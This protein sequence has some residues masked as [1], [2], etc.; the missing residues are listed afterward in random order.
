M[1]T[2]LTSPNWNFSEVNVNNSLELTEAGD[3]DSVVETFIVTIDGSFRGTD[4]GNVAIAMPFIYMTSPGNYASWD[5]LLADIAEFVRDL[6]KTAH[7]FENFRS[8]ETFGNS[9]EELLTI[10]ITLG[11][12]RSRHEEWLSYFDTGDGFKFEMRF[13]DSVES[14][15]F[16]RIAEDDIDGGECDCPETDCLP[17]F[18][19]G[20][21]TGYVVNEL[22]EEEDVKTPNPNQFT[23]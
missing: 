13:G 2:L 14:V 19:I 8:F 5:T 3:M 17:W 16:I 10:V 20:C 12:K 22:L 6:D 18:L 21:G 7:G 11:V 1:K 15:D 9:T 4:D 23:G